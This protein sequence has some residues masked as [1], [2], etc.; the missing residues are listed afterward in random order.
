M[1]AISI[2]GALVAGCYGIL[3]DQV[4]YSIS[5]EYFTK[6]KFEQFRAADF[7]YPNRIFVAEIGFLGT[8]WVGLCSAWFLARAAIPTW[9]GM[10]AV[11]RIGVAFAII[12]GCALSVAILGYIVGRMD[13]G[14]NPFWREMLRELGVKD[15]ASFICVCYIHY[16]SYAGGLL[17]VILGTSYLIRL[18]GSSV[19]RAG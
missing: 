9:Q 12:L 11:R 1:L 13:P 2:I 18:K 17:G 7:G 4:T 19:R 15:A 5:P 6:M 16:G 8:W 14:T 10:L 3:H